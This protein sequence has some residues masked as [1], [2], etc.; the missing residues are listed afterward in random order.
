MRTLAII[1]ARY[2]SSRLPGKALADL[3]GKSVIEWVCAGVSNIEGIDDIVVA[4]D[5]ERIAERVEMC[6]YRSM[7]TRST[8][9]SGTERC[10]EVLERVGDEKYDVVVNIQ[11]DEPFVEGVQICSLLSAFDDEQTQIAT[12]MKRIS[13][14]GELWSVNNVKVVADKNGNALYFSRQ[15]IP[16]VREFEK[17]EWLQKAVYYKHI[18]IYA[19][20]PEVLR[21]IVGLKESLLEASEKLEQLRWLENGYKVRLVLTDHENIGID[22]MEDL[23]V[24]RQWVTEHKQKHR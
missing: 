19:Y 10:G 12:L 8:H 13:S 23:E 7:M 11:G 24:A 5:D 17:G 20:R 6:G 14:E 15:T 2:G 22:T 21:E 3:C 9:R 18:G 1:P 16:C 4:T